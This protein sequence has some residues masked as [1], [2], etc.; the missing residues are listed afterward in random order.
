[1]IQLRPYQTD[2]LE[3]IRAEFK[4][5]HRS[6]LYQAPTGSG[7]TV[8]FSW[9]ANEVQSKKKRVVIVVHREE[10][11]DQVSN[12][13]KDFGVSHAFIAA[14]RYS[15]NRRP[16]TVASVWSLAKRFRDYPEPDL[17]VID[18]AHHAAAGSWKKIREAWPNAYRLGVTATPE[19]LDG[20]GLS[21]SFASLIT[22]PRVD[23][24]IRQGYLSR[25]RIYAPK[26]ETITVATRGGDYAKE[27]LASFMSKPSLVGDAVVHYKALSHG[28]RAVAFCVSLDHAEA[29]SASFVR[30]GFRS[31]R[32]DGEM[33]RAERREIVDRF[34]RG[35][36]DVLTSCEI[37]SEGFDLP[38]IECAILL[39]PTMSL[40]LHLQQVGRAL[41]PH[42]GKT[43]AIILDHA[44]NTMRHGMPDD[45]REWSLEGRPKQTRQAMDKVECVRTC[46]KCFA[47][48][49][50]TAPCCPYC[51]SAF[52]AK[53]REVK[54]RDGELE[55]VNRLALRERRVEQGRADTLQALIELGKQRNYR[56]PYFWAKR[57]FDSRR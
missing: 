56:N 19:R 1:M 5:G 42:P 26:I 45:E 27:A 48:A 20:A 55:E 54:E 51:G 12:T 47:A 38:A 22:G 30:A 14:D 33:Q 52:L 3:R 18:E 50:L 29:V 24:L 49:K 11:L 57:V 31:T 43:E 53:P 40:G 39:R 25:F 7:K 15:E 10:L 4:A 36:I 32:I 23:S 44:G 16:V 34:K 9:L 2:D 13:L 46:P 21:D 41:R 17:V 8:L 37:I 28:R 35:E 6:V